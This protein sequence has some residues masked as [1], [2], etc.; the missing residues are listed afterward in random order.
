MLI[1]IVAFIISYIFVFP[2]LLCWAWNLVAP[3]FW[4]TA[5]HLSYWQA[6]AIT[7]IAGF[8]GGIFSRK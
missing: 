3:V 5:P 7:I 4:V 8:I 1:A 2:L 6:F